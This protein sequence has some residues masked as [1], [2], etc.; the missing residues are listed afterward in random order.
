[1]NDCCSS[2][3]SCCESESSKTSHTDHDQHRK[4]V[5]DAYAEVAQANNSDEACG[6]G[7]SCCGTT[8]DASIN[9]LISTRLGY[10]KAEL[11]MVPSGADM[12]LAAAI[13][14]RSLH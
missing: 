3:S 9:A 4:N 2:S 5:R 13:P 7:A 14:R 1:M 8:D 11:D 12:G 6:I 10:S